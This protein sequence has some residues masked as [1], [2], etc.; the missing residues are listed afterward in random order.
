MH[1]DN[2]RGAAFMV[3]ASFG[4]AGN[5]A[6]MK[7]LSGE[8]PILQ[9]VFLRGIVATAL[10]GFLA[11]RQGGLTFRFPADDWRRV[12][13]RSVGEIGGAVCYLTAIFNMPMANASAILQ[14]VPL[15][16]TLAAALFL[17]E[18]VGW[19]RYAA[20]AIG[21]L[22]VLLIV[23]PGPDGFDTPALWAIASIGF[24]LLRDL[25]T[26]RISAR[27]P[28]S[29]VVFATSLALTASTGAATLA[30]EWQPLVP[31]Q[32]L[33]IVLAAGVLLV[34]YVFSVHAMRIGEI[35]F[36]Q[37]FRY[38]LLLWSLLLGAAVFGEWPDALMLL[39]SAI[40]VAT[41]LF[42]LHRER[43]ATRRV[44]EEEVKAGLGGRAGG[45]APGR[46]GNVECHQEE[47]VQ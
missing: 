41:G 45:A 4:F 40:V 6:L 30:G 22:G 46:I 37:P 10:I 20:A 34:G 43:V 38:T 23:R 1:S 44:R 31:A 3:V 17:G 28:T 26:R 25:S 13:L 5:D 32:V 24:I 39:G 35:G 15:V 29:A 33:V 27:T 7:S 36:V 9:A 16:V 21:F 12:G 18:T 8:V 14:S 47:R 11:W 2:A 42:T 19:R